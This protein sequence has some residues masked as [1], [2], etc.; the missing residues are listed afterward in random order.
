[1]PV[2]DA[3]RHPGRPMPKPT[4]GSYPP[5]DLPRYEP[6]TDPDHAASRRRAGTALQRG[7]APYGRA[8]ATDGE[9]VVDV[10]SVRWP[11]LPGGA[12][13]ARGPQP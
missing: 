9:R 4:H 7:Y 1:M 10:Q 3:A 11:S 8:T 13:H 2:D 5:D 6:V 12:A